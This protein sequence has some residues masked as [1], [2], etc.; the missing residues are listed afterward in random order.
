[1]WKCCCFFLLQGSAK[2]KWSIISHQTGQ[3]TALT[4]VSCLQWEKVQF[5]FSTGV[6][7]F[8]VYQLQL[9]RG[10][11][12]HA[13]PGHKH[14]KPT[15]AVPD[16]CCKNQ[17][18]LQAAHTSQHGYTGDACNLQTHFTGVHGNQQLTVCQLHV[19]NNAFLFVCFK[20]SKKTTHILLWF[21]VYWLSSVWCCTLIACDHRDQHSGNF[22]SNKRA[23]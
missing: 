3:R 12:W 20:L 7:W 11:V 15:G 10:S 19:C 22:T 8:C 16:W 23:F 1:M 5:V 9:H 13:W 18:H 14:C 21:G 2:H 17:K 6:K 4:S